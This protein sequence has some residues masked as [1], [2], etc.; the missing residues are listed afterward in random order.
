MA[1]TPDSYETTPREE[2]SQ[3]PAST[4][5]YPPSPI[6]HASDSPR[7][8]GIPSLSETRIKSIC[9]KC[10]DPGYVQVDE[11]DGAAETWACR[12]CFMT[13]PSSCEHCEEAARLGKAAVCGCERGKPPKKKVRQAIPTPP[14]TPMS[15]GMD[16]S[17]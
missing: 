15:Y 13:E 1:Y 3:S 6:S 11:G 7:P 17:M 5:S 4:V 14:S 9:Y 8:A 12:D 2:D 16:E 10:G